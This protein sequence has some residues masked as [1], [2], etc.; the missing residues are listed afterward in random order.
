[1]FPSLD[2]IPHD[3]LHHIALLG[4]PPGYAPPED[5]RCLLATCRAIYDGLN[6]HASPHLYAG[7][8]KL[9]Y[10]GDQPHAASA[11]THLLPLNSYNVVLPFDAAATLICRSQ[12]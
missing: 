8:F 5:L 2:H 7:I 6:I 10:D 1:M 11:P 9:K 4:A 12:G 3:V